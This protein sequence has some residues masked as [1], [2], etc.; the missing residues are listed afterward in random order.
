MWP[1]L[2][3]GCTVMFVSRISSYAG[4]RDIWQFRPHPVFGA[5]DGHVKELDVVGTNSHLISIVSQVQFLIEDIY[6]L[7]SSQVRV[8]KIL[9]IAVLLLPVF[10]AVAGVICSLITADVLCLIAADILHL[11]TIFFIL[12]AAAAGQKFISPVLQGLSGS[13]APSFCRSGIA[14]ASLVAPGTH[15]IVISFK[16]LASG[17][18]S[19]ALAGFRG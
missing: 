4:W 16:Q 8:R 18:H 13:A 9:M 10:L 2:F 17:I 12:I 5:P 11:I 1:L 6:K 3:I 19:R 15:F 7:A 14:P